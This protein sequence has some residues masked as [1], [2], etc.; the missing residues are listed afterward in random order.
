MRNSVLTTTS[1]KL[2][3]RLIYY[4]GIGCCAALVHLTIVFLLV[5]YAHFPA[6]VANIF[7]F[8][9]AFNVS[10]FGH[11][12]LTFSQLHDKKILSLPHFFLVAISAGAINEALYFLVLRLTHLNYMLALILVLSIVSIY[13]FFLSRY[14]AC[15]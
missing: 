15:R 12:Y 6:L 4:A 3:H 2:K 11:K 7:A 1:L 13:S 9:T 14:W 8:F 5:N 10:F